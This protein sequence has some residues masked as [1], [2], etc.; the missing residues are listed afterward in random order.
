MILEQWK[1]IFFLNTL[2]G[3]C[4][5]LKLDMMEWDKSK[6]QNKEMKTV[7]FLLFAFT[8][9]IYSPDSAYSRLKNR[10]WDCKGILFEIN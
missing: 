2:Y 4:L 10:H 7:F 9:G 8:S 6:S 1:R 5:Y 3:F